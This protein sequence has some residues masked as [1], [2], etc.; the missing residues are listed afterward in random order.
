MAKNVALALVLVLVA[1]LAWVLYRGSDITIVVNGEQLS[2]PLE[3]VAK[4]WAL[5]VAVVVLFCA[6]ILL[7]FVFAG[8]GLILLGAL[9]F[10][11]LVGVAAVFPFLLPLLIPLF[12]VWLFIAAVRGRKPGGG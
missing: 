11:S 9:V 4:G 8:I 7:I 5:L 12:L 3:L 6:A 2:G 1:L 10:A